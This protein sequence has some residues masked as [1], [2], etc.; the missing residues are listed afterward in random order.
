[1][2]KPFKS[3]FVAPPR[4]A[5]YLYKDGSW[6]I[7]NF[8]DQPTDLKFNGKSLTLAPRAWQYHWN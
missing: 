6:V 3:T 2:L 8:N 5:L 1:L 7:E 4:I